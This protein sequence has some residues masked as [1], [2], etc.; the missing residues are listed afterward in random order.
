MES[1]PGEPN[2]CA[3]TSCAA[4]AVVSPRTEPATTATLEPQAL[5]ESGTRRAPRFMIADKVEV[6][7]D[8]NAATLVEMSICGAHVVS[9]TIL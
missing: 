5:D 8:G 7:I 9:P 1:G 4:P 6:L 3:P 2:C